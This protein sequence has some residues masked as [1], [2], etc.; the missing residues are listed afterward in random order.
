MANSDLDPSRGGA[1]SQ[2]KWPLISVSFIL[3]QCLR[4]YLNVSLFCH[5]HIMKISRKWKTKVLILIQS[6]PRQFAELGH[7]EK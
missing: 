6:R 5:Y 1:A 7:Q 4:V 3:Q 2:A